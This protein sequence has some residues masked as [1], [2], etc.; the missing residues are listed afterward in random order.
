MKASVDNRKTA[1]LAESPLAV[2]LNPLRS[3]PHAEARASKYQ[4]ERLIKGRCLIVEGE[5]EEADHRRGAN[6]RVLVDSS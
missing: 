3:A 5:T 4:I 6:R 2:T 1:P